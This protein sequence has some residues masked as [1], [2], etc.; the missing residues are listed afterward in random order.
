MASSDRI[1]HVGVMLGNI[2][3]QHPKELIE[4]IYEEAS[5]ENVNVT[6]FLGAQGNAFDFWKQSNASGSMSYHYQFNALYDY[7]LISKL[8]VL[9]ISYGTLCI[10]FDQDDKE[11]FISKFRQVPLVILE[12]YEEGS[13]DSY[14]MSDNYGSMTNIMEHL[15]THHKYTKILHISGP[16]NNAVM[17][18]PIP[19]MKPS[20]NPIPTQIR[21]VRIRMNRN[22]TVFPKSR[23][24]RS[25]IC[26]GIAS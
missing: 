6:L 8:D 13:N 11:E 23:G 26:S 20:A 12:E 17:I 14:I 7:A 10:Y 5:D 25:A 21:S 1:Y 4:G 2:H 3:T 19:G 22:G 15:I 9:I 16:M 18:V 24:F